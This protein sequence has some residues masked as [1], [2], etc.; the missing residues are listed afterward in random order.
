[1]IGATGGE[2]VKARWLTAVAV[3]IPLALAGCS[4]SSNNPGSQK[5]AYITQVDVVCKDAI[6]KASA[7]GTAKDQATAQK[8]ADVWQDA[9]N[10]IKAMPTP[11]ESVEQARI[12]VYDTDNLSMAYTAVA[13]SLAAGDQAK[14]TTYF[15]QIDALKT[16]A[17]QDAKN[18]GFTECT[19]IN[20]CRSP[21]RRR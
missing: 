3:L 13:R 19:A 11:G 7:A 20:G 1:M 16:K 18:Y 4:S 5:V 2:Q 21:L 17:A 6:A 15:G 14:A 8:L 12:F 9:N 10:R